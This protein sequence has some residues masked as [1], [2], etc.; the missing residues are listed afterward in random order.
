MFSIIT[1]IYKFIVQH[2]IFKILNQCNVT[3]TFFSFREVIF[4]LT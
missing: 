3:A 2:K 1:K 4:R